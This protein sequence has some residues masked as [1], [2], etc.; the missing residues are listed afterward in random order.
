MK[1]RI[2]LMPPDRPEAEILARELGLPLPLAGVLANRGIS[3][4]EDGR[5]FLYGTIDDLRDPYLLSGMKVA[6]ARIRQAIDRKERILIFGDY[7]ADGVLSVVM[8]LKALGDLG[9]EADYFIPARLKDGYGL[10][11]DH[12]DVVD[13]KKASLVI[14]VDCGIKAHEFVG[15]AREKGIDV[16]VTD[17]HLPDDV[18]P[19]AAA[20]LNPVL[21]DSGYPERNLAGVGVVFKLLEALLRDHAHEPRLDHYLKLVSV[22]TIADV[23][24]LRGENRLFVKAGLKGLEKAVNPGLKSLL[25]VCGLKGQRVSE[26]DVAFRLGPRLNAA[27]RMESADLAVEL[28]QTPSSDRAKEIVR[29]LDDLNAQRQ[30]IEEGICGQAREKIEAEGLDKSYRILVLGSEAWHRGIIGIVAS[31]LKEEF[32]RPVI[33]FNY[34]NGVAHGSGRSIREFSL[35]DCLDHCRAHFLNYG[36][37]RLAVGCS[38]RRENMDAFKAEVNAFAAGRLSDEDLARKVR[39]DAVLDPAEI[40]S[41]FLEKYALLEPFG[42]GNSTPVFMTEKAEVTR[43]PQKLQGRHCKLVVRKGGPSVEAIGWDKGAWADTITAGDKLDLAYSLQ[44]S[45]YFGSPRHYLCLEDIRS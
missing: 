17:H 8:L 6:V 12:I 15:R 25:E 36:G 21:P 40:T 42:V 7:D 18:L 2:W 1:E 3:Q 14:S 19:P 13:Q 39:L 45:T 26:G 28:F 31:R 20:I 23:A 43:A 37:H 5:R 41:G 24:E 4:P 9:A 44:F 10:K 35:I 30:K 33:L 11:G 34:E 22:G 29:R 27:G 32:H 38:L 16:I